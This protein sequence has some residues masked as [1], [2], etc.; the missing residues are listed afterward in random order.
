MRYPLDFRETFDE[1][2]LF[3]M[4]RFVRSKLNSLSNANVKDRQALLRVLHQ[5]NKGTG[6]IDGLAACAREA[7]NAGVTGIN[8]YFKP[9][10]KL[11]HH[12]STSTLGLGS[13]KEI[14]EELISDFLAGETGGLSDATKKN[15]RMA[16]IAFFG[17]VDKQNEEEDGRSHVYRIELK[18]W[19]GLRGK[20]GT[21]LPAYLNE[22]E[23]RRFLKTLDEYPFRPALAIR[24]R[25]LIK[26]IL[27]T[28][29][30]I[31]EILNLHKKDMALEDGYYLL[32]IRGKGNKPRVVMVKG[33]LIDGLLKSWLDDA[34]CEEGLLFCN[35]KGKALTQAYASRIIEQVMTGAGL[36]K[37][38][39]GAHMLRHSFATKLYQ[40]SKD[41]VLVQESLGHA[42]INTS[43]IYTHFDK[44]RMKDAADLMDD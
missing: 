10:E 11:Y 2:L 41:L 15:H 20:S 31:S 26:M 5:L 7:R 36:R 9:L 1:T 13:M 27:F 14:D 17:Y 8:T 6:S 16:M 39:N 32:R 24:N 25:L 44:E 42:D 38:K 23:I 28:G 19:G 21:K 34:P 30:R 18:N 35:G 43:R 3:W 29:V 12:L 37:E 33:E 22:E 4:E 40:K